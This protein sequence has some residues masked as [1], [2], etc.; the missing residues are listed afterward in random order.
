[1]KY[2]GYKIQ[3][4]GKQPVGDSTNA[5]KHR[6]V[7]LCFLLLTILE[8]TVIGVEQVSGVRDFLLPGD[9]EAIRLAGRDM[10]EQIQA[11]TSVGDAITSFCVEIVRHGLEAV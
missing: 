9:P 5:E 6:V 1:M 11:G 3:Y 2:V 8:I 10:I 7:W 4:D